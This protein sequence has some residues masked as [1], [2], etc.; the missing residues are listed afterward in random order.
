MMY[1][2]YKAL[3]DIIKGIVFKTCGWIKVQFQ[4]SVSF[5]PCRGSLDSLV[6]SS[7]LDHKIFSKCGG[8]RGGRG[9]EVRCVSK[10]QT[11]LSETFK[12]CIL[13]YHYISFL[14]I[15]S[16]LQTVYIKYTLLL[17]NKFFVHLHMFGVDVFSGHIRPCLMPGSS[18]CSVGSGQ[19]QQLSSSFCQSPR[20][21]TLF[22]GC[23]R[24][25]T[26]PP[27]EGTRG[28]SKP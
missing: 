16:V 23:W 7:E 2:S 18:W 4:G 25:S 1:F 26:T 12:D 28:P 21:P 15:K 6:R 5:H 3:V 20:P 19:T 13:L 10:W 14:R 24:F 22:S 11:L 8:E 9:R 17:H 27:T